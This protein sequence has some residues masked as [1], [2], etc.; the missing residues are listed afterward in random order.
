[1]KYDEHGKRM[2]DLEPRVSH[3]L[4]NQNEPPK[5]QEQLPIEDLNN[6]NAKPAEEKKVANDVT[7]V[8][9]PTDNNSKSNFPYWILIAGGAVLTLGIIFLII[10]AK[11][12]ASQK[13]KERLESFFNLSSKNQTKRRNKEY[14][15]IAN[16]TDL[17]W[18]E[19]YKSYKEKEEEKNPKKNKSEMSYV[20]DLAGLRKAIIP[21]EE[22][23]PVQKPAAPA[24]KTFDQIRK[25]K[26]QAKISKMEHALSQTKEYH[27]VS[28]EVKSED[29]AIT[30][31][32][33]DVKLKSFSK[34]LSLKETSRALLGDDKTESRNKS[35]KEGRF[36]KLKNS[37]LSVTSRQNANRLGASDLIS[38]GSKYLTND[39]EM[40]MNKENENYL[41][42]SLDE[43]LSILDTEEKAA[44]AVTKSL[45]SIKSSTN[46]VMSRSGV[47]NPISRNTKA[48]SMNGLVVKSGYNI[49][50]EKGFYLVNLDG[51]SA[52]VGRVKDNVYVLKKFEYV[53]DKPLQ[54]RQ[55]DKNVYIVKAGKFKC[56]VD[57]SKE[58][59]GTLIEI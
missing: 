2:I 35:Y 8:E 3:S 47:T 44:G 27:E 43:Y 45:A 36:I 14:Y 24:A 28:N 31:Q 17:N 5:V 6:S 55:D 41:L 7:A 49:D 53:V 51:V 10:D 19:K 56:L 48:P 12:K 42:S 4:D 39:G 1:M 54:V 37:P 32:M 16:S 26:L 21:A 52:L 13:N 25:E 40:K 11:I 30:K 50:S 18:Q 59:M 58:K 46:P 57:V 33:S 38:T 22:K 20:T 29:N 15:D 9:T 23:A 34:A